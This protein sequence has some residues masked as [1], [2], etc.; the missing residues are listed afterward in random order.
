MKTVPQL[1]LIFAVAALLAKTLAL[2]S[3][4]SKEDGRMGVSLAMQSGHVHFKAELGAGMLA[5]RF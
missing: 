1:A 3:P 4:P 2:V 5:F